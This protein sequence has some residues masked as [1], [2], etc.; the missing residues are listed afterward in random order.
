MSADHRL[1]LHQLLPALVEGGLITPD[2]AQRLSALPAGSSQHPLEC[3]AA[4][5]PC[6]ETLTQWLAQHVGQ[7]YLRIDPLKIDVA[8]VVPLMSH[9]FAQRHGIAQFGREFF[10]HVRQPGLSG[11]FGM[12]SHGLV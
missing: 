1:E 8:T 3:I 4:H 5:G 2:I 6:L 7:P 12:L 10:P 11:P 9:A